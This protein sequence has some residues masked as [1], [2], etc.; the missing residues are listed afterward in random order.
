[1]AYCPKCGVEVNTQTCPLCF[2]VI[3]QDIHKVPFSHSVEIDRKKYFLTASEKKAIFNASSIF[4]AVLISSICITVDTLFDNKISWSVYP[5]IFVASFSFITSFA[6]YIKG[7]FKPVSI[8]IV[9][10]LML[11]L[12]DLVIP[13]Q[14]FFLRISLPISISTSLITFL[15]YILIRK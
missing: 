10:L 11:F 2:H 6:L 5:I 1:M 15:T 14:S 3:K 4:A 12:L 8:F 9:F 13:V 7:I